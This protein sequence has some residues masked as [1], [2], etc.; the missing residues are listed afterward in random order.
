MGYSK[1]TI[2]Y[3]KAKLQS[4]LKNKIIKSINSNRKFQ[5][6]PFQLK[7]IWLSKKIRQGLKKYFKF[8]QANFFN[9]V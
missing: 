7:S 8:T 2:K 4:K 3:I 9:L 5:N 6:N 1:I